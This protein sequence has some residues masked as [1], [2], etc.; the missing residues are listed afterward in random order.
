MTRLLVLLRT[1]AKGCYMPK[2][3]KKLIFEIYH[4]YS[5]VKNETRENC[6]NLL[7]GSVCI[8]G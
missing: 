1:C 5:E 4:I 3:L 6:C 8:F 7:F 2:D